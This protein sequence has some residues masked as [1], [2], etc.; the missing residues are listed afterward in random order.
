MD[1]AEIRSEA[2]RR[3]KAQPD[4]D[5]VSARILERVRAL[6]EYQQARI[7]LFYVDARSEVRTK[8]ALPAALADGK[9]V[10]VPW[11]NDEGRLE[12]FRLTDMSELELGMYDI[13]EPAP[14][15]RRRPDRVAL[16]KD[17][18]FALI[19]G[20]A[21]DD[22][23]GRVGH[24]KGYYDKLLAGVRPDC[25]L[26][27]PAFDCQLFDEVPTDEHDVFMDFVVTEQRTLEGL[28]RGG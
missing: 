27:A 11:C 14:R 26:V 15:L 28:G 8:A 13:L 10:L 24:G 16:A 9:T 19:P 5:E 12:L 7:V 18:D 25:P 4:K 1:K 20:V 2:F 3:R 17:L 6:P 21:F 22:R 23:G